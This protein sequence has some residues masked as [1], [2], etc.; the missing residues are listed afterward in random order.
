MERK[1]FERMSTKELKKQLG[2]KLKGDEYN[3]ALMV[4]MERKMNK[5]HTVYVDKKKGL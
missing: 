3:V 1:D 5:K 4:Y 2:G